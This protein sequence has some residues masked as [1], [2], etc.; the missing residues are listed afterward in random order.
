MWGI[1]AAGYTT[2]MG[3]IGAHPAL[4][5]ASPQA[6]PGDQFLGDDYHH[7]GAFRLMYA[8][9]WTSGNARIRSGP[10]EERPKP[11]EYGTP[12]GYRF[13][14]ELGPLSNVNLKYF[15]D[16]VPT[17][18]EFVYHP[19]YDAYWQGKNVPK[20]MKNVRFAVL[21]VIGWFDAEDYYGPWGIY[22]AVEK[23]NPE[24][25]SIVVVGP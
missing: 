8:F 4:M 11:F 19:A 23:L 10:T 7:Y 3:M 21:N 6:S 9:D 13:F 17:W 24:N 20:D 5:A 25:R 22:K 18:N 14:R 12:D 15:Q 16:Q 1:S 2:A